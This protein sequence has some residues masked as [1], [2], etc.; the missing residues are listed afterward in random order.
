LCRPVFAKK[1]RQA[2]PGQLNSQFKKKFSQCKIRVASMTKIKDSA[3]DPSALEEFAAT[4]S[5][6]EKTMHMIQ[7]MGEKLGAVGKIYGQRHTSRL[8]TKK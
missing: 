4:Q 8:W 3:I 6:F 1:P 7:E 2:W 5:D